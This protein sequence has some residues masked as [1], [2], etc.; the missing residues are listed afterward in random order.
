M[1][2]Q[3][4]PTPPTPALSVPCYKM[5]KPAS[6][7]GLLRGL[8]GGVRMVLSLI[9]F[10]GICAF[11]AYI[12][13]L[14]L[15]LLIGAVHVLFTTLIPSALLILQ[16][17]LSA[18]LLLFCLQWMSEILSQQFQTHHE[19]LAKTAPPEERVNLKVRRE[20]PTPKPCSVLSSVTARVFR[21]VERMLLLLVVLV[22]SIFLVE[23]LFHVVISISVPLSV[24]RDHLLPAMVLFLDALAPATEVFCN[25]VLGAILLF[26]SALLLPFTAGC[27]LHLFL[28]PSYFKLLKLTW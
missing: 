4:P 17:L 15:A 20:M 22:Y 18:L 9:L 19:P 11:S 25:Q 6:E 28:L 26:F 13:L 27:C 10:L 16:F 12:G 8:L 7:D 24:L 21:A 3:M 5:L 1:A 2:Q 23:I 14:C